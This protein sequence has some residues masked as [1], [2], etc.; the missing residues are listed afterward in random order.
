MA[1]ASGATAPE[2]LKKLINGEQVAVQSILR[3]P[4]LPKS[5]KLSDDPILL[6]P[7]TEIGAYGN[8]A[9]YMLRPPK[10]V[11]MRD[12]ARA[13]AEGLLDPSLLIR[14]EYA[15]RSLD[16]TM[17]GGTTSGVVYPLAVCELATDFCFRSVGGASAGAIAAAL[18][19]AAELGRNS[20]VLAACG[21]TPQEASQ[22]EASREEDRIDDSSSASSAAA[23]TAEETKAS[24]TVRQGFAGLADIIGWLTQTR[25]DDPV[26]EEY[27]LA[28]L[29]RPERATAAIFRVA[30]AILRRRRLPIPL[31]GLFAFGL[32]TRLLATALVLGAVVL[33]GWLESRFIGASHSVALIIGFGAVGLLTVVLSVVGLALVYKS[34]RS[35]LAAREGPAA[36]SGLDG[37]NKGLLDELLKY[38]S[39]YGEPPSMTGQLAVG[40]ILIIFSVLLVVLRPV[41]Y[42]TALLVGL[43]AGLVL[44]F[45]LLREVIDYVD[46]FRRRGFGFLPGTTPQ[47]PR[48]LLD[49]MAGVPKPTVDKSVVPWLNDCLNALAGLP[50]NEVLRFGH[51]WSGRNYDSW[52]SSW[53]EEDRRSWELMADSKDHRLINLEL[54]TTDLT[55]QRPFRF[56]LERIEGEESEQLWVCVDQLC[57]SQIFPESITNALRVGLSRIVHDDH[58]DQL[59]LYKLPEPWDLPVIFAVRISMSLPALFQA[60]RLYRIREPLPLQDDFGRELSPRLAPL[61]GESGLAQ[62][63]WFSDGGITSNF[64]VHFFDNA[65]PRWPTVSLNLGIHP[66]DAPQQDIW[67]PQD[68]QDPHTPVKALRSGISFGRAIFNTAM[69]WHDSLQS[70]LPGYRNRIAQVRT[71]RGEGGTNLFMPREI[72]ASLALRGALAGARLRT[73]FHDDGQW[74]RFRWLRLRTAMSNIEKMRADIQARRGFYE[75][76]FDGQRWLSN[77]ETSFYEKPARPICWYSPYQGFW[78]KAARLLNTFADAYRPEPGKENAMTYKTPTPHPVI[79]Q[80]PRD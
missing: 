33:T 48:N 21:P 49:V 31:L 26:A 73:R 46:Q 56:P 7:T 43:A 6:R 17:E 27:R 62:E 34:I 66:D 80:V 74:N 16:L 4:Y 55:R 64:P 65:L 37:Q 30:V 59:T 51:L 71:N 76:A 57:E 20:Q 36:D 47:A 12:L 25:P 18:T 69:S 1:V 77:Q 75:D 19:A 54:M 58:G 5:L 52:P 61:I 53:S 78:P 32:R 23:D 35:R 40:V 13:P 22:Q 8:E 68:W 50:D 60:V 41:L 79:R 72:I 2:V 67:L 9:R 44:I 24:V 3:H 70:S 14:R 15:K 39:T 42:L 45:G 29:F 28:Q 11:L 63:L 10:P 38:T